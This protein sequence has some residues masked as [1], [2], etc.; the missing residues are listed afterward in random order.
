MI[1]QTNSS[2]I[3]NAYASSLGESKEVK[4]S[5]STTISQQGDTSRVEQLKDAINSGEYKVDL[6]ALS[7]KIAEELLEYK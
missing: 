1:S 4:Q 7:N 3:R 2:L 6:E 5:K